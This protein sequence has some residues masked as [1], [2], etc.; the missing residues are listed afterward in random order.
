MRF[1]E[2]NKTTFMLRRLRPYVEYALKLNAVYRGIPS[3]YAAN[4]TFT[5]GS[6]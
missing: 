2:F 6:L 5:L 4:F 3:R 1:L